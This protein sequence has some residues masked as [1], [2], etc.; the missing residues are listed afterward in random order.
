MISFNPTNYPGLGANSFWGS[1][2][3][4]LGW[5][6][7]ITAKACRWCLIQVCHP[8]HLPG[9]CLTS[10][11]MR[12]MR[13]MMMMRAAPVVWLSFDVGVSLFFQSYV[14]CQHWLFV[15]LNE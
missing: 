9:H 15:L 6:T 4:Y 8:K 10:S 5:S 11:Q 13:W 14:I 3:H 2:S 12:V 1:S 7:I